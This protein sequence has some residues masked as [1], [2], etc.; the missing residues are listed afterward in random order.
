MIK[1]ELRIFSHP[2]E[3]FRE[4]T[5]KLHLEIAYK[6]TVKILGRNQTAALMVMST[7]MPLGLNTIFFFFRFQ[8][9]LTAFKHFFGWIALPEIVLIN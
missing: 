8:Y 7:K 1:T 5:S 2:T 9:N 4:S 6:G 3:D